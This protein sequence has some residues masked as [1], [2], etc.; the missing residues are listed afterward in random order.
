MPDVTVLLTTCNRADLLRETL[1]SVARQSFSGSWETVVADNAS[2]DGTRDVIRAAQLD[3]PVPL[4][5]VIERQPGKYAAMN[6]G[7]LAAAGEVIVS[8]DDDVRVAADW[9]QRAVEGFE[10]F[11]CDY[12]GGRVRPIWGGPLP[13]WIDPQDAICGK[14]LALQDHGPEPCE[15]GC[16]GISWPL[17]ANVAYRRE[18]FTRAG[19]FETRLGRVAGTLRNQSQREWH[20]RARMA[21]L[22]GMYLPDMVVEHHVPVERMTRRYFHRWFYWHGISRA[23]LSKIH[24]AHLLEPEGATTHRNERSVLGLPTSLWRSGSRA[25]ISAAVR[26][27]TGRGDDAVPYELHVTFC[28]GVLRQRLSDRRGTI[29]APGDRATPAATTVDRSC[30]L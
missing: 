9:V 29:A 17:G 20:L 2:T 21:G 18:A 25:A 6:A 7:V 12:A 26:W 8:S 22:R 14:V 4:R 3:F 5:H 16:G 24:G 1:A 11:G 23:T 10:R 28:A 13:G 19:M 30:A 27:L 15:Y